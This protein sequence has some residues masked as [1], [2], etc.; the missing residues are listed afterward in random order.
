MDIPFEKFQSPESIVRFTATQQHIVEQILASTKKVVMLSAPTGCHAINTPIL[1]ADGSIKKV[2]DIVQGDRLMGDDSF[3]RRVLALYSGQEKMYKIIPTKGEPFIVNESHILSLKR[4]NETYTDRKTGNRKKISLN[5]SIENISVREYLLKSKW[6]KHVRKLYRVSIDFHKAS[7]LPLDPYFLGVYLGDGGSS[8]GSISVTTEDVE[9]I[10]TCLFI[11]EKFRLKYRIG[12]KENNNAISFI[13]T[14]GRKKI[15]GPNQLIPVLKKLRL[16]RVSSGKKFIPDIYKT[17]KFENRLQVLAGLIDTDG[18]RIRQGGG[19]DYISKS[20]VLSQGVAFIARSVGLAAYV[21]PCRKSCQTGFSGI[22]YRVSISGNCSIIPCKLKRKRCDERKQIKDVLVTGFKVKPHFYG[23]YFGFEL[24]GNHLYCM[25]DFTVTHN[26]GKSLIAM[27][28]GKMMA[29]KVNYVC[30]GKSLQHQQVEDFP[31]AEMLMGR[32]NY[33]CDFD[34]SLTAATC[35]TK[36]DDYKERRINCAYYDQKAAL[37]AA[38]YRILNTHYYLNEVNFAGQLSKQKVVII[39]EADTLDNIFI[40]FVGL[41]VSKG[42]SKKLNIGYP[43]KVTKLESWIEWAGDALE[44]LELYKQWKEDDDDCLTAEEAEVEKIKITRLKKNIQQFISLVQDDW[45]Y[46]S[47]AGFSEFKPVWITPEVAEKFLW[48][49]AQKFVLMSATLPPKAVFAETL[50]LKVS[51]VDFIEVGSPYEIENRLVK[52][53]PI[54]EMSYKNKG[55]HYLVIDEM[56]KTLDEEFP[57]VK[58]IIH[59]VSYALAEDIMDIGNPRL[60]THDSK[61]RQEVLDEFI[62]S[63]GPSVLVSPSII[64]GIDLPGDLCRFVFFPKV[65]FKNL[66]DKQTAARLFGAGK[67]GQN[68]YNAEASQDIVQGAGRDIRYYGDYGV[69]IIFD[70]QFSRI[71][72]SRTLPGWFQD[73]IVVG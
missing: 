22:Y 43:E 33:T 19:Y 60:M 36:C 8:H 3:P 5:G 67:R 68:W 24:D 63:S 56:A 4:T 44:K 69:A 16:H 48:S 2:Q 21:I 57:N 49:H 6:Y 23:D 11:A 13:F 29:N 64:R 45:I 38:K 12:I 35:T 7:N 18:S 70:K 10:K 55:N 20:Q 37:I 40:N 34:D 9:I 32:S 1:M 62:A 53:R 47:G 39:D 31:E 61:D 14:S 52:Y 30:S 54:T 51:D 41:S 65:P 58:G 50:G 59:S 71:L 73:A 42:Q 27:M 28:A 72:Q 66:K 26:T 17:S 25:G 46:S 15:N